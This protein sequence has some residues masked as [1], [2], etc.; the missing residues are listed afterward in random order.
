M[1][2]EPGWRLRCSFLR[3][4]CSV[5]D[6]NGRSKAP[7]RATGHWCMDA[8]VPPVNPRACPFCLL[9][10]SNGGRVRL[11]FYE[12]SF[13]ARSPVVLI[14]VKMIPLRQEDHEL[15]GLFLSIAKPQ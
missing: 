2:G 9:S 4:V 13:R 6:F 3:S 15:Y 14:H 12:F 11:P 10:M 5:R 8:M 7:A 1:V